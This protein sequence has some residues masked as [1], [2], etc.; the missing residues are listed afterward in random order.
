MADDKL[1]NLQEVRDSSIFWYFSYSHCDSNKRIENSMK[2]LNLLW[3][4]AAL[5]MDMSSKQTDISQ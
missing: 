3:M 1:E 4:F 5:M 2:N